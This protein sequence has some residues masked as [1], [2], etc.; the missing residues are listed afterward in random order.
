M[1]DNISDKGSD[2]HMYSYN[3]DP[4]NENKFQ[5]GAIRRS[6]GENDIDIH[7]P[8]PELASRPSIVH[9][10]E[11]P[12]FYCLIFLV[13]GV[14]EIVFT[15]LFGFYYTWDDNTNHPEIT[16][17][18]AREKAKSEIKNKYQ[19][20]QDMLV[21]ILLGFGFLRSSPKHHL[22]SSIILTLI[23]G[24]VSFQIASI[25]LIGWNS[26][27]EREWIGGKYNFE[28][29]LD[30]LY[31]TA[32]YIISFGAFFGKLTFPQYYIISL[33]ETIFST[34]N[35][36]IIRYSLKL[37]DIGGT[38]TVH[39]FA[40]IFGGTFS[41]VSYCNK[42]EIERISTSIHLGS[43]HNSILF[44]LF[45]SL[46]I[47]PYWP[48]FNTA[49]VDGNQKYRGII[50]TY[51]SIGGSI[52]G[53]FFMSHLLNRRKFKIEDL[54]YASFPGAIVI[55]GCCHIIKEFYLCILFGILA[56]IFTTLMI[57]LFY[58]KCQIQNRGYHDT[59]Q[60]L[61]Y[62]GLPAILGGII[63]I[64]F[65]ANLD[66]WKDDNEMI[67]FDYNKFIGSFQNVTEFNEI[68]HFGRKAGEM[69]GAIFITIIIAGIGGLLSG[70][71]NKFCRCNIV[72]RYFND[73]EF[74]HVD[75]T[76]PFPWKDEEV[77]FKFQEKM[78]QK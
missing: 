41:M 71:S 27:I 34:L 18:L 31:L 51:F 60:I 38:L 62:H 14:I 11:T 78:H 3:K 72:K 54:I 21:V 1:S 67:N 17:K 35:Y 53:I 57:F 43:D 25:F 23:G 15:T 39:L 66:N 8:V 65:T 33:I 13:F 75:R 56:A 26:I 73:S 45:G 2:E 74:F 29:F 63:S 46:I 16:D 9:I 47:I 49:L 37:I 55:A 19:Y 68:N 50:N 70:F 12:P 58:E 77:Q 30:A 10:E 76:E 36:I 20:F 48:S 61:F 44:S 7:E 40:A 4:N 28:H 6:L 64:I 22:W 42:N 52:I 24:A 5:S 32:C 69:L 59:S